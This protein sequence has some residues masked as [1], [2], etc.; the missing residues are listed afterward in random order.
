MTPCTMER[1]RSF[2]SAP[3]QGS[4]SRR[5]LSTVIIFCLFISL[6]PSVIAD[7]D[8]STANVLTDGSSSSDSVDADGDVQD[9]WTIDIL[10]GDKLEI[11][12]SSPTGDYGFDL[13]GCFGTDHWEGKVQVWDANFVNGVPERGE[14]RFDQDFGSSGSTQITVNVNPSASEWG[15]HSG[16]TTWYIMVKSKST[17]ARDDFDY[18]VTGTIDQ[19]DR[20]SDSDGFAD[21]E[22]DCDSVEGSSTEDRKGCPDSDSDGWSDTGDRFPSDGTQW[23]DI[24]G[25]G[26]GDNPAPANLPDSC[27]TTFGNSDEDRYGCRDSDLDGWSDPDPTAI[28][29]TQPWNISDGADAFDTDSTQWSDFDY[30]GYGDNWDDPSWN[31]SRA[32]N[33]LGVWYVGATQPDACPTRAGQSFED[34]L[35]CPDSDGDGWSNPD[36]SWKAENG[37]DAFPGDSTQ[38]SDRDLDGFGDNSDGTNPDAF[39]DNPTQWLDSDGD[40]WGDNQN[41]AA[42]QID[43]FPNEPSQWVDSDSDGFGD[44]SSGFEADSC[45]NRA[46]TS[47]MDRFGCP[48]ADG[49]GY[50]NSDADW[51]AHPE[52]F[53]DAFNDQS[54]QWA[55]TDGDG[56]GDNNEEGAWRPDACPATTGSS[57][58]D[59]WGCPDGDGDGASDPQIQAGWLP[60]PAG[61][62][63]AFP[64][65]ASQWRD[66][67]GD[68][69]GDEPVG[70]DPDR[71]KETPGTSTE[72]RFGCTDTDGDGWSDLG[73]RF[74][75]DV[76]Q[77]FD[78]DGD[79]YGDNSWGNMPDS[80]PEASLA[81]GISLL[82]RLGCPDL[83]GDGY[84]DPDD[85][86]GA[87]PNGT[88][89]AF[90]QNRVQWSDLDGDGFGDN[91]IGSL[92]DDCPEVS[93]V[94]S[95][96]LQGCPDANG[97]GY[98]DSFGF[99]N[100]QYMLMASNPT[101][102]MFTYII[103]IGIFLI[104]ILG[105]MVVRRGG[106]S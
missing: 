45:M 4:I 56:F 61:L 94:S 6:L 60:H 19:Y 105:M 36:E 92:R 42:T 52:G 46:G 69:Y 3:N 99:L 101:A 87:S 76:T 49:D 35:G 106:E 29:A 63:D 85:G 88:A 53:A 102:A 10:T 55:D 81:D 32:I 70:T 80:C 13:F 16:S 27:P 8:W 39:P 18:S 65:D 73:D 30:D 22:D 24:D 104:T 66:L 54:S 103:P 50:S 78:A 1:R 97:D 7:D 33:G 5:F 31:E 41:P 11:F 51:P 90:P 58:I 44:N 84:S 43:A 71:C 20:D 9:W 64:E 14:N 83:D 95:I 79:G 2:T 96:D 25:D 68:G 62:A 93:G 37:S 40:G 77:W 34:R 89:D 57:T 75:M 86:W 100:S 82:D 74:P 98:S 15:S 12:V 28:Y 21:R 59:R 38:W 17:C 26:Y 72:D 23:N 91:G 67:D 47:T 48:D